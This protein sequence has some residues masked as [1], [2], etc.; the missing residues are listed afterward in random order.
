MKQCRDAIK[1]YPPASLLVQLPCHCAIIIPWPPPKKRRGGVVCANERASGRQ[2]AVVENPN[3]RARGG[4][5]RRGA[6]GVERAA[7]GD[8]RTVV[9]RPESLG[10]QKQS[11]NHHTIRALFPGFSQTGSRHPRTRR[12]RRARRR[13]LAPRRPRP[14]RRGARRPR[15]R[16]GHCRWRWRRPSRRQ[17]PPPSRERG[18]CSARRCACS[19]RSGRCSYARRAATRRRQRGEFGTRAERRTGG[20]REREGGAERGE[21]LLLSFSFPLSSSSCPPA[22]PLVACRRR[23]HASSRLYQVEE[24]PVPSRRVFHEF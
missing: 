22:A 19:R 10:R 5:R 24:L 2:G 16:R 4:A 7:P 3:R 15:R 17:C 8:L 20:V 18:S 6:G 13:L 11:H 14:R 12:S 23:Q 21:T 9:R 1:S